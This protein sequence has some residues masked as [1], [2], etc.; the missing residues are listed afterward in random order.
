MNQPNEECGHGDLY[1]HALLSKNK[2]HSEHL[3]ALREAAPDALHFEDK[4]RGCVP[5]SERE[6]FQK[7]SNT[8][9]SG[10]TIVM[11]WLTAFGRDFSQALNA[12]RAL[13]E[14]GVTLKPYVNH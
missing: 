9:Q 5:P 1:L 14:K 12:I 3:A 13:L 7:L 6:A 2:A 4:I 8:I 10:D 11:W